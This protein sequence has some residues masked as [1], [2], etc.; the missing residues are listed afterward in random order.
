MYLMSIV[1]LSIL[2]KSSSCYCLLILTST[3][4]IV[5]YVVDVATP[6][7]ALG[8]FCLLVINMEG[9]LCVSSD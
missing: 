4:L 3:V 8:F 9:D 2:F 6:D 1:L 7:P 5:K